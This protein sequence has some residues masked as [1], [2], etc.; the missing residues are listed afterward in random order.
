MCKVGIV[1]QQFFIQIQIWD[2]II[3]ERN[4]R[5]VLPEPHLRQYRGLIPLLCFV[6]VIVIMTHLWKIRAS[7]G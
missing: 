5:T 3:V 7:A 4:Y 1:A 6:I 2:Q